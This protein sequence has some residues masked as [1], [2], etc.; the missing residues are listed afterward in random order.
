[1]P[2]GVSYLLA[3]VCGGLGVL[4][5]LWRPGPNCWIG[6]RLPWTFADRQIWDKSWNLGAIF[7]LGMGIGALVSRTFFFIAL[8]HLLILGILYPIFLYWRKYGTLRYWRDTG[9]LGY[10]PMVRCRHCQHR[11]R[12]PEAGA[13]A[14]ARCE[15]CHHPF[16]EG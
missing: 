13:L 8:A 14:Q 2:K 12:L 3:A 4:M 9:W 6:V 5:L 15:S 11:Q 7:L 16:Q 1:M 10:H